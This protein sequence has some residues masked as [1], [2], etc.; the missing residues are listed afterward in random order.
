MCRGHVAFIP[1]YPV[2]RGV[3]SE[4]VGTFMTTFS[5]W[6]LFYLLAVV[7]KT[8]RLL[9]SDSGSNFVVVDPRRPINVV[10]LGSCIRSPVDHYYAIPYGY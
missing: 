2:A 9:C 7:S 5:R 6:H 3:V 4:E 8:D 10:D 1:R